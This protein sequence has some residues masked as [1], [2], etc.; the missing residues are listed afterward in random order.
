MPLGKKSLR[1]ISLVISVGLLA[2]SA[3]GQAR[4][5]ILVSNDDGVDAPGIEA[6]CDALSGIAVV[7]VAAPAQ[8]RSGVGHGMNFEGPIIVRP[9]EKSGV[10]WYAVDGLPA[11]C[12]R[13]GLEALV[14]EKPDMVVSGINRGEN[15]GTVTFSSGTVA[16]A[17]EAAFRG[18]PSIAVSLEF[19]PEMSYQAAAAF[20]I[21]LVRTVMAGGL[22]KKGTFLNV[23]Y[24]AL[25]KAQIKGILITR[26]D[27]MPDP[28]GYE[29]R[30]SPSG[31][32]YFWPIYPGPGAG[33]EKT[34]TW[35][36]RNGYISITPMECDQT[37]DRDFLDFEALKNLE[38]RK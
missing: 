28:G 12:V 22:L 17:R 23:N 21:R 31:Q 30:T 15:T 25:P 3:T 18:I 34:D 10:P 35:A 13:L 38:I 19:G 9:F 8:N 7:V 36:L 37:N 2:A 6:L 11:T 26:Q 20:I 27:L 33:G 14:R 29:R 16:C 1:F 4:P 5:N 32:L 24:P